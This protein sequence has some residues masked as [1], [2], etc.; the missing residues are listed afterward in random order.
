MP[1]YFFK[2]LL[3]GTG[4]LLISLPAWSSTVAPISSPDF[5]QIVSRLQDLGYLPI[6]R[7]FVHGMNGTRIRHDAF[8]WPVPQPLQQAVDQYT[9]NPENPFIRGAIIQFEREN[10]ILGPRGTSEGRLHPA[11]TRAL[12]L[13]TARQNGYAYEW[14][15]VTKGSGTKQPEQLHVWKHTIR[16]NGWVW[17]TL[18]N[19]GVLGSTPNGTWPIYQRLPVTTMRG[20][21]PVP[22]SQGEYQA[23]AG[24]QVPQWGGATAEMPARGLV[25]GHPV[26]WQPY[27]DPGIRWVNYFDNGRGIHYYPRAGYGFPQ[28]AGCVEEPAKT[29]P[30]TYKVL[31]YGVPVTISASVFEGP[32]ALS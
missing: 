7:A 21:F 30:I 29:A 17:G 16:K 26:V 3:L 32:S 9:W 6:T 5:Q 13:K 25:N 20:A 19:T 4:A 24:K 23:L 1:R 12:F 18:V 10:G 8:M 14:V 15:Y 28:S 27:N 11:V 22:V 2:K 31:H